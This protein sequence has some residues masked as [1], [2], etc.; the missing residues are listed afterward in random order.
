MNFLKKNIIVVAGII[1][2]FLGAF[3]VKLGNPA[4]MGVCVACFVR[5]IAG[6]VGM[7]RAGVVQYIRPEVIGFILGSFFISLGFREFKVKGGSSPLTRFV[8]G[9]FVMIGALV[10]LGCPFRMVLRLANGD[11][12]AVVALL[13]FVGG[14]F[15][16]LKA[17]KGGFTLGKTTEQNISGGFTFPVIV[18][19]LLAFLVIRPDFIFFSAE[20]PGSFTA[21]IMIALAVGLIVGVIGQR[22]RFCMAGGIRDS[23]LIKDF[24]MLN[25]YI[26]VFVA[27]LITNL[28]FNGK[29][30]T[31]NLG[32]ANQP[33]AHMDHIWNFLGMG[34]VGL[35]SVLLGGCPL[36]QLILTGEGNIDS[37]VS[38]LGML[39][40]AAFAH[41]FSLA[42]VPGVGVGTNGKVAVVIG[43][44]VMGVI[45]IS[46]SKYIFKRSGHNATI[47]R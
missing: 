11:L 16:G 35:G 47:G 7:H 43:F 2:G 20:G 26:A 44:V 39:V 40:G 9:F 31:F 28:V 42:G 19:F 41:N 24:Y 18:A 32:F 30:I 5:D 10:F 29:G 1:L 33:I 17:L 8:L 27:A 14:I 15:I 3:L 34:L 4:N 45:V 13:G 37:G 46:H 38:V 12:N 6:A 23:L 21:P 36:R 25:G 22:S